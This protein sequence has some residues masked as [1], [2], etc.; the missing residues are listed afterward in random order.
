VILESMLFQTNIRQRKTDSL[1][2][3]ITFNHPD[4]RGLLGKISFY[5]VLGFD[6]VVRKEW[7]PETSLCG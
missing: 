7:T 2:M 4:V 5:Y 3:G 1:E 6:I